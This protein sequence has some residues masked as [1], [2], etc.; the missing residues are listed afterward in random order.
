M[1]QYSGRFAVVL[2][3]LLGTQVSSQQVGLKPQ[4]KEQRDNSQ[5][6]TEPPIFTCGR[7]ESLPERLPLRWTT[8]VLA[9]DGRLYRPCPI[10]PPN[11][12]P[13]HRELR[14]GT[15]IDVALG[16]PLAG[17]AAALVGGVRGATA[18]QS[19]EVVR[20]AVQA[21]G[22]LRRPLGVMLTASLVPQFTPACNAEARVTDNRRWQA[23]VLFLQMRHENVDVRREAA[24]GIVLKLTETE[25]EL[26]RYA[27]IE[28]RACLDREKDP[29]TAAVLL[30]GWG[31]ARYENDE[32]RAQAEALLVDQSSPGRPKDRILGATKALEALIRLAPRRPVSDAARARLR[33][34][35]TFGSRFQYADSPSFVD[36]RIRRLAVMALQ[37]ARDPDVSTI[38]EGAADLDW[39]VRRLTSMRLNLSDPEQVNIA[40]QLSKD[41]VFQV[42][43]ELLGAFSRHA[44]TTKICAP[45]IA[46]LKDPS[47][48]VAL[49]AMDLITPGC[50]D[51]DKALETLLDTVK[52]LEDP[53]NTDTWHLPARAFL[54]LARVKPELAGERLAAF[55]KQP[56][57]QVR[58]AA[59]SATVS[60]AAEEVALKLVSD[61]VPNV[62]NAALE[63]LQRMKSPQVFGAAI[64]TLKSAKD[65]QLLRT[66]ALVLRGVPAE[67]KED[68]TVALLD[69][70]KRLTE[71]ESDTSRD[72]RVA[73]LQRLAETLA[74]QRSTDLLS[75]LADFDDEVIAAASK[76]FEQIV[77]GP[78]AEVVNKRRRYP[79]QPT[80]TLL[81]RLPSEAPI[82]FEEGSVTI[83]LLRD[84]A[85][86]TV[87]RFAVLAG[88][89]V[90]N[91]LT[92]H[93][94][95]P[96]F[97][98]QGGSPGANEYA[99][100]TPRYM[101]DEVGPRGVHIRGA[102]G[103]STR[104]RDTGD[105]QIF[106]D[107]VDL[108]RLD[109]D[110][111]VFGYVRTGMDVVDKLLE[112]AVIKRITVK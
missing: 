95:V 40:Q 112:G 87:A 90:Y 46:H 59:A 11:H 41:P 14:E 109:R 35:A 7:D 3:A 91:N 57:W 31:V 10:D 33:E 26:L 60:L 43:Y 108:P 24:Y 38:R 105:A 15:L 61:D 18:E 65:H 102:V 76:S 54:A 62:S 17:T 29:D 80:E 101:R 25:G 21:V 63:A 88:D 98:V 93:R 4:A 64:Q 66:A 97:V 45:I 42:R 13:E 110:Y 82:E 22:H 2:V 34:L 23:G 92:F 69:A 74:P 85:P 28:L 56:I 103:I 72:P 50:S 30:E 99:G 100:T 81:N 53:N 111:T 58:A 48:T 5:L 37:A 49:R 77:G 94:V 89:D 8:I 70:L 27:M 104:G 51:F 79:M 6:L 106:I 20:R 55:A 1:R 96:N 78:P 36:A 68:A 44:T 12:P 83:D 47:P 75:Y 39:Q 16:S 107:L 71:E 32:Q 73:I 86:V 19:I 9:G 52:R 67:S 84:V